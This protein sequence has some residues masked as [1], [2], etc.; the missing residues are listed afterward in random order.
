[1]KSMKKSLLL[2]LCAL[3]LITASVFGTLAYLTDT[4]QVLN[5]FT[6]GNVSIKLD[7]TK[8]NPDGTSVDG[9]DEDTEPDRTEEGNKYHLIPGMSYIKDPTVTVLQGSD[10]AYVRMKVTVTDFADVKALIA[11]YIGTDREKA[12]KALEECLDF[13]ED[14]CWKLIVNGIEVDEANNTAT[15]EFRYKDTVDGFNDANEPEDAKLHALFTSFTVPA[16]VTA[17]DL[18][19][20][21]EFTIAIDGEAMQAIGFANADDAWKE[22]DAQADK[23]TEATPAPVA[24]TSP[25]VEPAAMSAPFGGDE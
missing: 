24:S 16:F 8:V 25:T 13:D 15:L 9:D 2:V 22:F 1:M 21:D 12:L 17:D 11:K 14:D 7:E 18:A 5:T 6:V 4:A 10:A 19:T 3:A 20:L 23:D